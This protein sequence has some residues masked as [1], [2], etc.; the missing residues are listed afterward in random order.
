MRYGARRYWYSTCSGCRQ[1][2]SSRYGDELISPDSD[3]RVRATGNHEHPAA[4]TPRSTTVAC[5]IGT[6]Q[7]SA[8]LRKASAA[9]LCIPKS[10]RPYPATTIQ[11]YPIR[12]P[13][14][15]SRSRSAAGR[16]RPSGRASPD[17]G[18]GPTD[19]TD[20]PARGERRL[21]P[22]TMARRQ[23][24]TPAGRV[25]R[26]WARRVPARRGHEG[27]CR[28]IGPCSAA[29]APRSPPRHGDPALPSR[30]GTVRELTGRSIERVPV[31]GASNLRH[32]R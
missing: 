2:T 31:R 28:A 7:S 9:V 13:A 23:R 27:W 12:S 22:D 16:R 1:S 20:G 18:E 5:S 14:G 29:R 3:R 19:E 8:A 15:I 11:I 25:A 30:T 32:G 17:D 10:F 24:A 26:W 6:W 4:A 21:A